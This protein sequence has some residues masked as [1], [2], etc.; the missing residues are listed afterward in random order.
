[1]WGPSGPFFVATVVRAGIRG[2]ADA[3]TCGACR[4]PLRA[5]PCALGDGHPWPSTFPAS[6]AGANVF[7]AKGRCIESADN[8][9]AC[10]RGELGLCR[11]ELCFCHTSLPLLSG[12]NRRTRGPQGPGGNG[13]PHG[14]GAPSAHG[15]A[16]SGSRPALA[17]L[18]FATQ[19]STL[20]PEHFLPA[21][22]ASH[23]GPHNLQNI[24]L[25]HS[26][27]E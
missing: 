22:D 17:A 11:H 7:R 8:V 24:R 15:C 4:E 10:G 26:R 13:A 16:R 21:R 23:P 27:H 5:H 9:P 19:P 25:G 6:P 3:G 1:M 2:V 14:W 18:A 20:E 12:S